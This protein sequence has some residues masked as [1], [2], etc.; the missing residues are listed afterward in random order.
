M[1]GTHDSD[2]TNRLSR[3][4][5]L[6]SGAATAGALAGCLGGDD[7]GDDESGDGDPSSPETVEGSNAPTLPAVENPPDA[8]Y[9]PTH[10]E[11]MEHLEPVEA[12]EYAVTPMLTY[13]HTFWLVTGAEREEVTPQSTGVHLMATVWDADTGS[14]I[15]VDTGAG[16]RV[17][18]DG[19]LVDQRAPWPMISQTMGF[20]FGDNVPLPGHGTYTVEFDLNPIEVRTTGAFADRF[21]ESRTATF[22]FA[23]DPEFQQSVNEGVEYLPEDQWGDPGALDPMGGGSDGSMDDTGGG[24][25]GEM[26]T[27]PFSALDPADAYPG[28]DLGTPQ[29]GDAAFV[30]R[31]LP[32]SRLSDGSSGYLLVS[33]RTPYNRVPLADM[34]LS[35]TGALDGELVQTLDSDLGH[36]YGI[37]GDLAAGDQ[38]ELVVES[39]PQV[40][41]HRGYETAFFEMSPIGVAVP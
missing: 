25:E 13:P 24:E 8:V 1:T 27:M 3:R 18:R 34:A 19:D 36:H 6:A 33:P 40:A 20:H 12:G 9:L 39:P 7:G 10:R 32:E 26:S 22:E 17:L 23:F 41:R 14:V 35:V 38:L 31:Y 15:P 21:S 16:M 2:T 28:Q 37:A 29:S 5:F 30:V 11:S 4:L